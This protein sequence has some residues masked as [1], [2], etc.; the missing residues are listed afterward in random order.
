[1][2]RTKLQHVQAQS[3]P[4]FAPHVKKLHGTQIDPCK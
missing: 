3:G 4:F 1:V 2:F